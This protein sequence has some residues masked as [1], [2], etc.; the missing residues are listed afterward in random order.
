MPLFRRFRAFDPRKRAEGDAAAD[1]KDDSLDIRASTDEPVNMGDW[2]EVLA[3]DA[4]AVDASSARALLV[5]HDP[6][7]IAGQLMS[8]EFDGSGSNVKASILPEARMRSG[9]TVRAAVDSG[10]LRGVSIGYGYNMADTD[11]DEETRTLRVKRWSLR[12]VSLTPIPADLNAQVRSLPEEIVNRNK[13]E[14]KMSD[15]IK[16]DAAP[17]DVEAARAATRVEAKEVAALARSVGLNA[18]DFVGLPKAEAQA[19]MLLARAELDAKAKPDPKQ[20]ATP[21]IR[22]GEDHADK[23]RDAFTDAMADRVGFKRDLKG[24]PYAGRGM[25]DSVR[26]FAR[27]N[28]VRGAEDWSRKDIANYAL[29]YTDQIAGYRDAAN[30]INGNFA[31]FV[32]L[33]AVTKIVATG[34]E[35]GSSSIKY[36][37]LVATQRVPD[38]KTYYLGGLGTGNLQQTA[39]NVAFPELIKSEGVYSN[40]AKMWGGTLSLTFQALVNDDTAQF[41]RSLRMAGVIAQKTIDRRV[42]QKLLMGTS[43]VEATSTWTS[44]T[45]SGCTPVYTT[46]DTLAA[47]RA[48]VG[49]AQAALMAKIGLDANPT[50]NMARFFVAGPT[51]GLYLNGIFGSA[52]GQ[53][54]SN[55]SRPFPEL[56]ITPWLEAT[57]LIGYSTTS[58]YAVSD[59]AEVTTLMLSYITGYE[60][61]QVQ[62]YDAGAIGARKWKV[63]MPFEADLFYDTNAAGTKVINGAQQATT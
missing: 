11:W 1:P 62:E 32:T 15:P 24:N 56:I 58:Y 25:L 41:D 50:G 53:T 13:K 29:N 61:P 21:A 27:L 51:S 20:P 17:V 39:E 28:G 4:E 52:P 45:T 22:M 2:S 37:P 19:A 40:T 33:N 23:Q 57:A 10:A 9:V 16:P 49:K 30:I 42:F 12:E 48:N 38:F 8:A 6:D 59:P 18:D 35:M 44:N 43:A 14:I 34:F 3:H 46:A 60:S 31:T 36:Q 7:Q 26:L 63:W 55:A 54:V 47:A 5:N